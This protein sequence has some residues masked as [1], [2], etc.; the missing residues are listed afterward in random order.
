MDA[1]VTRAWASIPTG[2]RMT[3]G[4]PPSTVEASWTEDLVLQRI[5]ARE[6]FDQQRHRRQVVRVLLKRRVAEH[7]DLP[8][9]QSPG[10]ALLVVI[11]HRDR[12]VGTDRLDHVA[13]NRIGNDVIDPVSA[14]QA[15]D[16]L[17]RH[18]P[19]GANARSDDREVVASHQPNGLV[20]CG[21]IIGAN[22][23]EFCGAAIG[24]NCGVICGAGWGTA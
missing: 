22:G 2:V 1:G 21:T 5:E 7:A 10:S 14:L 18:L 4:S 6:T 13:G 8:R 19:H 15:C 24:V 9:Y 20:N 16:R 12:T 23:R 3:I 17:D 11:D